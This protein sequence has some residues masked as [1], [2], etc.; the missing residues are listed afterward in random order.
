MN[1]DLRQM[2]ERGMTMARD[3]LNAAV[4]RDPSAARVTTLYSSWLLEYCRVCHH[5][6][7]EDDTV[8]P[9]PDLS[10]VMLHADER[11]GLMCWY[12]AQ[13]L[14]VER[15]LLAQLE[16]ID[17]NLREE[18]MRGLRVHWNPA[19]DAQAILVPSRS[20]L[21]GLKCPICRHTVRGGD[22]VVRCSCNRCGGV[23][24]QDI[25]RQLTCWEA[26]TRS[27]VRDYCAFIGAPL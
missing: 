27:G 15:P 2:L 16:D 26:W 8:R 19:R 5:T 24:H 14:P 9:D 22:W 23:F 7:R 6:F 13:Q 17:E 10:G 12:W 18:F 20:N 25:T 3:P 11:T 4:M 21:I 1:A